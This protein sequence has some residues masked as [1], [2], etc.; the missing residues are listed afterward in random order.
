MTSFADT[1]GFVLAAA[2]SGVGKTTVASA[3]CRA[4]AESRTVQPFKTGPDFIDPTYLS[5]AAGRRCR[6]LDG[7]P[8]PDL[9][10]YF[11]AEGC[12]AKDN[13]PCADIAVVEGVMGMYDGLGADGLYSTAWLARTLGLPVILLVDAKASVTSV[14]ATAKGFATLA[15]LAP[16]I[17][18][19][20]AN[21]VSGE[22]HAE[23]VGEAVARFADIP[24]L[25]WL[26]D[27]KDVFFP[28]R[29]LGLIP[30]GERRDTEEIIGRF[31][32]EIKAHVDI[33]RIAELAEFP[34]GALRRADIPEVVRK[35]NGSPVRLAIADDEAF[36][37][38]YRENW[39][40]FEKLGAEIVKTSPIA[41]RSLPDADILVL[42]GGYPEEFSEELSQNTSYLDSVREFSKK[43][44]IYAE[45]GGMMYLTRGIE[46]RG[47]RRASTGLIDAEVHMTGGLRR[48]GYVTGT[49]LCDN[50]LFKRG[51]SVRAHEFHYSDIEGRPPEA[52]R[53]RRASGRGGEWTDGYVLSDRLLAT[54]LHIN[55]YSCPGAVVRFLSIA[56]ST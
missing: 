1:R 2:S 22:I 54:Y 53:V 11:Y 40:L 6:N 29:H 51:E 42:P 15:P 41:D 8:C 48:F 55:F 10:A 32:K 14:A 31:V 20:I 47:K 3:L 46:H 9:M 52:F 50:M 33:E 36:C 17:V 27:V 25:G 30:A 4:L 24:L 56:S 7:F 49:A 39:E 16:K 37:F 28:S 13:L 44:R 19:V 35:P 12:R 26:P 21:R 45:C 5:L 43:G 38:H 34:S 18:G 23:M